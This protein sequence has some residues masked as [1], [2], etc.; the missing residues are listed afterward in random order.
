[1]SRLFP[2]GIS[3]VADMPYTLYEAVSKGLLFLGF[4]EELPDDE[5]PPKSIWL[6]PTKLKEWFEAVKKRRDEKYGVDGKKP[7]EDPKDNAAAKGLIAG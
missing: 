4:Q 5:R 3:H 2:E 7:I 1:M 6:D